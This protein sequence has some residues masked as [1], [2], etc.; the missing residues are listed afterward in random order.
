MT[1]ELVV[2][3]GKSVIA[4]LVMNAGQVVTGECLTGCDC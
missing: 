1:A 2:N 3:A 4:E